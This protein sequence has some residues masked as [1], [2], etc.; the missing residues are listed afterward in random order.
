MTRTEYNKQWYRKNREK[1]L[2]YQ[3]EHPDSPLYNVWLY[4]RK[5]CYSPNY[6]DYPKY[7]GR[8]IAICLEWRHNPAEFET[9]ARTN[10]WEKGLCIHRVNHDGDYDPDN[11]VFLSRS[12]HNRIHAKMRRYGRGR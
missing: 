2:A 10:G 5:K 12:Q 9:W 8:G 4:L 3:N 1:K 6:R 11:C 7:G